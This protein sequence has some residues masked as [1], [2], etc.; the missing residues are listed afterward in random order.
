MYFQTQIFMHFD[1]KKKENLI[2]LISIASTYIVFPVFFEAGLWTISDHSQNWFSL[3]PSWSLTV[4]NAFKNGLNFG[5]EF[6]L[7]YGPLGFLTNRLLLGIN[8]Y[9][10]LGYDIFLSINFFLFFYY[11]LRYSQSKRHVLALIIICLICLPIHFGAGTSILL[12]VIQVFWMNRYLNYQKSG[13]LIAAALLSLVLLFMKF[14]TGFISILLLL[15]TILYSYYHN[16]DKR[17]FL[18]FVSLFF[19]L[20][21]KVLALVFNVSI[22]KYIFLL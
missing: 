16:S 15:T 14:N 20:L 22:F 2:L 3:D 1:S 4:T 7:T 9:Y 12:F 17:R 5:T 19:V 8:K 13:S 10:L 18:L 6:V 11:S 21:I